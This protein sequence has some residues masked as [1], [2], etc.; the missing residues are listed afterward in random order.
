M[1]KIIALVLCAVMLFSLAACGGKGGSSSD[2]ALT[3][4]TN[5]WNAHGDDEKFFAMGGDYTNLVDGAPGKVDIT[6]TADLDALLHFPADSVAL[7][8]DAASLL[9]AMN[10]NTF[11]AGVY[12]VVNAGDLEGLASTLKDYIASTQWMC[13]FPET[14]LI[15]KVS[16][17][18]LLTAW[19]A[20][21]IVENFKTKTLSVYSDATVLFEESLA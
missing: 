8:D 12:H 3:V 21:D 4:L 18:I 9:H 15:V 17:N 19:G 13:G 7:I 20:A 16:D 5:I 14:L 10:L 6:A 1:K 11:S 2:D